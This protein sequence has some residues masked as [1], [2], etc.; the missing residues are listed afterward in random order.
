[1]QQH[2]QPVYRSKPALFR[3]RQQRCLQRHI[4]EIGDE[5]R[6]GEQ[7]AID[8]EI[9]LPLHAQRGRIHEQCRIAQQLVG[10]P[11]IMGRYAIA[12]SVLTMSSARS[13]VRLTTRIASE[14]PRC[15]R[16]I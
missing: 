12:E 8:A 15:F 3:C 5:R 14:M 10:S 11:Q 9:S 13:T 16:H 6:L 2:A 4:D 1:M 7:A